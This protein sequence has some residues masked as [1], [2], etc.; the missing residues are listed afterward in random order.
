MHLLEGQKHYLVIDK[1]TALSKTP[2]E[3]L[4][5]GTLR[6]SFFFFFGTTE[7]IV[8]TIGKNVEREAEY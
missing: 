6:L 8:C 1:S 7:T 2:S 5:K 3:F 4:R